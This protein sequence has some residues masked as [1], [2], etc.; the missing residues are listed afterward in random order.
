VSAALKETAIEWITTAAIG[1]AMGKKPRAAREW[2]KRHGIT[3]RPDGKLLWARR[4]DVLQA[5]EADE[6]DPWSHI[7]P[8]DPKLRAKAEEI[9]AEVS[10]RPFRDPRSQVYWI[11]SGLVGPI[12][13]GSARDVD[14][15]LSE[16]QVGNPEK[17][18]LLTSAPGACDREKAFHRS[19]KAD[20]LRGEWFHPSPVVLAV[21]WCCRKRA[22]R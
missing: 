21:V 18:F 4:E 17:L 16:L 20:R 6:S 19:L 22:A 10:K 1:I 5:T 11:R 2:C 7:S 9:V 12:K 13:I 3:L 14:I 8:P 15:R